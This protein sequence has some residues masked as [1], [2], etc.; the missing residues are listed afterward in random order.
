MRFIKKIFATVILA[1]ALFVIGN[2]KIFASETND[3]DARANNFVYFDDNS[4]SFVVDRSIVNVLAPQ[5][6]KDVYKRVEET[7]LQ[8][9]ATLKKA[10]TKTEVLV[11]DSLH[12]TKTIKRALIRGR[13]VN[14]IKYYWNY[15]RIKINAGS[16]SLALQVGFTIGSVYTP[17]RIVQ[18][19]CGVLGI[20]SSNIKHGIWF[21][22]NYF[23]GMLC[24]N[25]GLQ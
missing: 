13:G 20:A 5:E 14:S 8:L 3:V 9:Q 11:E 15:A 1:M 25:M 7:N 12:G 17:A 10:D 21:D 18:A 6:V 19:V 24:G 16:L 22:Y 4:K 2:T 23:Y